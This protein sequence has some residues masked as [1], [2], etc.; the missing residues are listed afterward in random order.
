MIERRRDFYFI[1]DDQ[2]SWRG[3]SMGQV[4]GI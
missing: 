3:C 2:A 1:S 4:W